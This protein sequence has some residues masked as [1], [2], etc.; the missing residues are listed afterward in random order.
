MSCHV[1]MDVCCLLLIVHHMLP[2]CQCL[3]LN[4]RTPDATL[5]DSDP[6]A[7]RHKLLPVIVFFHGGDFHDGSGGR[8]YYYASSAL[9]ACGNVVLLTFNYR[10]E[11]DESELLRVE[12]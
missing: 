7:Q 4:I 8:R 12:V 3:Y 5:W 6:H 10:C 1:L 2:I 9:P 11:A